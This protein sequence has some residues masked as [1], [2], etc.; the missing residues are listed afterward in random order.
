M[1]GTMSKEVTLPSGH[2][3]KLRDP[4]TL[5]MKDRNKVM[6]QASKTDTDVMQAVAITNGLIAISVIEWSFDLIPP[7]VRIASLE[8]LTPKDYD[9]LA[10]QVDEA[11]KYLFPNLTPEGKDDPKASTANSS[12]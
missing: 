11:A 9:F 4:E 8:E 10:T 3:V 1:E 5:L 2:T 6:E 12:D 7:N